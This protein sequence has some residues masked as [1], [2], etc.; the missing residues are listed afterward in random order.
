MNEQTRATKEA[1]QAAENVTKQ[2]KLITG[3]NT[4][5][6]AAADGI[7]KSIAEIRVITDRNGQSVADARSVAESLRQRAVSRQ[8][9]AKIREQIVRRAKPNSRNGR[10]KGKSR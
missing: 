3:A 10:S 8:G 4:Q 1:A 9:P 2:I 5:H 6:A 7:L